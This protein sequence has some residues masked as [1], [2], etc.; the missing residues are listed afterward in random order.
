MKTIRKCKEKNAIQGFITLNEKELMQIRGGD[1][2][3]P[4]QRDHVL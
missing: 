4:T 2:G 3:S 1:A